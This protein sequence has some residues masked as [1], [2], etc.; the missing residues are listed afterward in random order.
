MAGL[1]LPSAVSL[2]GIHGLC[3][4]LTSKVVERGVQSLERFVL[5]KE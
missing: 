2:T 3:E 4:E 1:I 5:I